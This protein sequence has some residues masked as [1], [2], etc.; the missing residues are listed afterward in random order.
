MNNRIFYFSGTGNS[1]YVAEKIS[2]SLG[3]HGGADMFRITSK[4]EGIVLPLSMVDNSGAIIVVSPT[5]FW[6]LPSVVSDFF[7]KLEIEGYSSKANPIVLVLTCGGST[8]LADK[9]AAR[10]LRKKDYTLTSAFS[11]KMPDNYCIMFDFMTPANEIDAILIQAEERINT[12]CDAISDICMTSQ[13]KTCSVT[14]SGTQTRFKGR[15]LLHRGGNAW[16][17]STFSYPFYKSGRK[18]KPF[19]V[20]DVCI[21]CGLCAKICPA[22]MISMESL[23]TAYTDKR[24]MRPVWKDGQCI[25]CLACLHHCPVRAIQYGHKTKNS[26]RYL[27]P[28]TSLS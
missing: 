19:T 6:G 2:A 24:M 11:V 1:K 25:Q 3:F 10:I 7:E 17:A 23:D 26:G 12:I 8:G 4:M 20:S 15:N 13:D 14:F 27:N 22:G 21:E 16:M 18:T 5:Y 28:K 9:M